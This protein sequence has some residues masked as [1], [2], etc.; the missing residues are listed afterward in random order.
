[1]RLL[2]FEGKEIYD[3]YVVAIDKYKTDFHAS[4]T[5]IEFYINGIRIAKDSWQIYNPNQNPL[6]PGVTWGSKNINKGDRL[7][8]KKETGSVA[9]VS[10]E[11]G[12]GRIWYICEFV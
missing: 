1:M 2:A 12:K 3:S 8:T 6:Y 7:L 11:N 5:D 4:A 9:S 10:G